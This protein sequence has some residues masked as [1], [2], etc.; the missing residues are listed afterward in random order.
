MKLEPC[1]FQPY[2]EAIDSLWKDSGIQEAHLRRSNYELVCVSL[3]IS[4]IFNIHT[5]LF[6]KQSIQWPGSKKLWDLGFLLSNEFHFA[7]FPTQICDPGP[8]NQS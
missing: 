3:S 4:T 8:Q 2:V 6:H 7:P 5:A 1:T